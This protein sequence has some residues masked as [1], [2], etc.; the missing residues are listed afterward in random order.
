[1][2]KKKPKQ[3]KIDKAFLGSDKHTL[4]DLRLE[5]W[6]PDRYLAAQSMGMLH[7][8]VGKEGWDQFDRT[9]MYPGC[10]KDVVIAIWLCSIPDS[11]NLNE[12]TFQWSVVDADARPVE[13]YSVAKKWAIKRGILKPDSL[14]WWQAYGAFSD[15]VREAAEAMTKPKDSPGA[16]T[17]DDDDSGGNG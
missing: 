7:P 16:G 3:A 13:A 14:E 4:S 11:P 12:G 1:M 6:T 10:V 2:S 15:M 8:R 9:K 17:E 5:P